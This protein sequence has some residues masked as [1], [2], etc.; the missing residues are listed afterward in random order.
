MSQHSITLPLVLDVDLYIFQTINLFALEGNKKTLYLD[1]RYRK[2]ILLLISNRMLLKVK[3]LRFIYINV[4]K[5]PKV[6]GRLYS[7]G[8]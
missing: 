4:C 3:P 1:P 5:F 7:K 8:N 6:I 2:V